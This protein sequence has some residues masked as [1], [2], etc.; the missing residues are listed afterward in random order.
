MDASLRLC[1]RDELPEGGARGFMPS[2]AGSD[3]MFVVRRDGELFAYR[4]ACPHWPGS[5]MAW[6]RHAYLN[7]EG[8]RIV[9]NG[10][11]AEFEIDT[12]RC[13]LGPCLGQ[14]LTP[15]PLVVTDVGEVFLAAAP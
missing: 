7:R 14:A 11:G 2:R 12:G 4:D 3:T 6:R 15:V 1:H 13:T 5:A 8:S 9:C 10:H